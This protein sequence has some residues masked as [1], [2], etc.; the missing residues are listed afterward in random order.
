MF[1]SRQFSAGSAGI[2]LWHPSESFI[3]TT[4]MIKCLMGHK[5]KAYT[6]QKERRKDIRPWTGGVG[7]VAHV[8]PP[9]PI[10]EGS[11]GTV[12]GTDTGILWH[13]GRGR[14]MC[15]ACFKGS[16]SKAAWTHSCRKLF[17]CLPAMHAGEAVVLAQGHYEWIQCNRVLRGW[18]QILYFISWD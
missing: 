14:R 2:K 7:I 10:L 11:C 18:G 13:W 5:K 6:G 16:G 12:L 17:C 3:G 9:T 4:F 8:P 15:R 1:A